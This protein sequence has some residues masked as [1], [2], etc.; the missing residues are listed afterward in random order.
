MHTQI[1][2]TRLP[3]AIRE[4]LVPIMVAHTMLMTSSVLAAALRPILDIAA[5]NQAK[6]QVLDHPE[7]ISGYRP[8]VPS[9]PAARW[10]SKPPRRGTPGS[11]AN[12]LVDAINEGIGILSTATDDRAG[13]RAVAQWMKTDLAQLFHRAFCFNT[14]LPAAHAPS[15]SGLHPRLKVVR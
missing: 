9:V 6:A 1:D 15:S 5:V 3:K 10:L 12:D 4:G 13:H 14:A 11:V 2:I 7:A 8:G